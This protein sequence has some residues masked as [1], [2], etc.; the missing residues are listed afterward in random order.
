MV[1]FMQISTSAL[2]RSLYFTLEKT[3]STLCE[4]QRLELQRVRLEHGEGGL[5]QSLILL[6]EPLETVCGLGL[7]GPGQKPHSH[8]SES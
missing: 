7:C 3:D 5:I 2:S 8:G 6:L 4:S 1:T